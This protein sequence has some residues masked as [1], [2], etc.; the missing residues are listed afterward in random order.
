MDLKPYHEC[1]I[2]LWRFFRKWADKIPLEE[3]DWEQIWKEADEL[4]E[5]Y[6]A[7]KTCYKFAGGLLVDMYNELARLNKDII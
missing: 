4:N 2:D 6:K 5:K 1:T 7:G 3:K